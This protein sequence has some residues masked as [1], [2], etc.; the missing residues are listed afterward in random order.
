MGQGRGGSQFL[1]LRESVLL[2]RSSESTFPLELEGA[3]VPAPSLYLGFKNSEL[4]PVY[5]SLFFFQ[6]ILAPLML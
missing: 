6:S 1:G 3:S 5:S 4:L 2:W